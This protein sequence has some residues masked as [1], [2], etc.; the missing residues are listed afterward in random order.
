MF[1]Q[2]SLENNE[3]FF[4]SSDYYTWLQ[5]AGIKDLNDEDKNIILENNKKEDYV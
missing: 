2:N 1:Y 5:Y 3:K 4:K